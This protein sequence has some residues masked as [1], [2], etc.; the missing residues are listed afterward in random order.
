MRPLYLIA[1]R[2]P[3]K[4][5]RVSQRVPPEQ[6]PFPID[7]KELIRPKAV[8]VRLY[9]I[10][11]EGLAAL[12]GGNSSDP[13]LCARLGDTE[14]SCRD[15]AIKG[16]LKPYFGHCFQFETLLPGP[17]QLQLAIY[18]WDLVGKDDLIGSTTIDLEDRYFSPE[19]RALSQKVSGGIGSSGPPQCCWP[20]ETR[21]LRDNGSFKSRGR[22]QCWVDVLPKA[23][24]RAHTPVD[25]AMAP[26]EDFELRAILY[27]TRKVPI[28]DP[29]SGTNDAYVTATLTT[30]DTNGRSELEKIPSYACTVRSVVMSL[31]SREMHRLFMQSDGLRAGDGHTLA[32]R[33]RTGGIQ[34]AFSISA[35]TSACGADAL[36]VQT[37]GQRCS[38]TVRFD[39][40]LHAGSESAGAA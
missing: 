17:T 4:P 24:A 21:T 30:V 26:P 19:W 33:E 6:V 27:R 20:I 40:L 9:V 22:V 39:R 25:I 18:D 35:Q 28:M 8:T 3:S 16:T 23:E 34:L 5:A 13:Y 11:A 37:L 1:I 2:I 29:S 38:R 10:K 12:D 7:V 15:E 32:C 14:F 36:N 31:Y